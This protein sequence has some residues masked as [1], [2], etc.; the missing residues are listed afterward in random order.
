LHQP[1]P[2]SARISAVAQL[3]IVQSRRQRGDRPAA[4]ASVRHLDFAL[5]HVTLHDSAADH[6]DAA[7]A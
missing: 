6:E 5:A 7:L 4:F 3:A 1:R 2:S